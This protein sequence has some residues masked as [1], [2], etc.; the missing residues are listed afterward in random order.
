MI[1]QAVDPKTDRLSSSPNLRTQQKEIVFTCQFFFEICSK[2]SGERLSLSGAEPG[3]FRTQTAESVHLFDL[4]HHLF[5]KFCAFRST[6]MCVFQIAVGLVLRC[7]TLDLSS[8]TLFG[9][10]TYSSVSIS[11]SHCH[12]VS[13]QTKLHSQQ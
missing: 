7:G 2:R 9:L 5:E 3:D 12:N 6:Q 10:V 11:L 4:S 8:E 13:V 1:S